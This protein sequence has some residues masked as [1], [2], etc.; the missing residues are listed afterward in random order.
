ML[1]PFRKDAQSIQ[2]VNKWHPNTSNMGKKQQ[3]INPNKE[4]HPKGLEE[5]S[6]SE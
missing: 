2:G 3:N 4:L 5:Q 1:K 6:I